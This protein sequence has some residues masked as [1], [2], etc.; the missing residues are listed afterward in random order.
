[1]IYY[2]YC[3]FVKL[4]LSHSQ[5]VLSSKSCNFWLQYTRVHRNNSLCKNFLSSYTE[6]WKLYFVHGLPSVQFVQRIYRDLLY[7]SQKAPHLQSN[8]CAK[9][10]QGIQ[11]LFC[12]LTGSQ[13]IICS[14]WAV[15]SWRSLL[16]TVQPNACTWAQIRHNCIPRLSLESPWVNSKEEDLAER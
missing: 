15:H 14:A 7:F 3:T 6:A 9:S 5:K 12:G 1:M 8:T 2:F 13:N 4:N 10:I 11:V 16:V